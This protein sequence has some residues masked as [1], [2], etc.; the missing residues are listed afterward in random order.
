MCVGCDIEFIEALLAQDV[1]SLYYATSVDNEY[2]C[3]GHF[4]VLM[5]DDYG[6]VVIE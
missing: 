4:C 2:F 6:R 5:V 1:C 3:T